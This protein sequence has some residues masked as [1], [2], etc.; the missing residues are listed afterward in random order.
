L[1][2]YILSN[3]HRVKYVNAIHPVQDAGT[4]TGTGP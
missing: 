4:G 1:I 3:T 2:T